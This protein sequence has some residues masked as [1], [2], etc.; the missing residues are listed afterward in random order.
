MAFLILS[1]AKTL[2][3]SLMGGSSKAAAMSLSLICLASATVL[4]LSMSTNI[5]LEAIAAPQP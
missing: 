5:V 3:W 2:Q 4:P 1:S